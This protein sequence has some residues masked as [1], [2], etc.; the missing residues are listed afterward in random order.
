MANNIQTIVSNKSETWSNAIHIKRY[1]SG[2]LN[3]LVVG[4]TFDN[5][6][7]QISVVA[8]QYGMYNF[9]VTAVPP[10]RQFEAKHVTVYYDYAGQWTLLQ[11]ASRNLMLP[12]TK[13]V[14]PKALMSGFD[15]KYKADAIDPE[16]GEAIIAFGATASDSASLAALTPKTLSSVTL[17]ESAFDY[18]QPVWFVADKAAQ[19]VHLFNNPADATSL[20]RLKTIT[21]EFADAIAY[22]SPAN[23]RRMVAIFASNGT[24]T[25][26]NVRMEV[27][28]TVKLSY[29]V[30]RVVLLKATGAFDPLFAVF[31]DQGRIH[32]LDSNF[33]EL[34][35]K[36]DNYYVNCHETLDAYITRDGKLVGTDVWQTPSTANF[37]YSFAPGTDEAYCINFTDNTL[38]RF[39]VKTS[40]KFDAGVA[41][42]NLLRYPTTFTNP[43]ATVL[44]AAGSDTTGRKSF[45][46]RTAPITDVSSRDWSY[47]S[48]MSN[49]ATTQLYGYVARPTTTLTHTYLPTYGATIPAYDVPLGQTVTFTFTA[50]FDD[51]DDILPII[52][53]AGIT[54]EAK[55]KGASVINVRNG[56]VVTVTASHEFLTAQPFPFS[57]GRSNGLVEVVPD[58]YPDPFSYETI[59]DVP[60]YSWQQTVEKTMTGINE[61]IELTVT[62]D[63]TDQPDRVEL[64]VNG[65]LQTAPYFMVNGDKFYWRIK[66]GYNITLIDMFAGEYETSW[67]IYTVS[68]IQFDPVP[69]RAYAEVGTLY[70][71]V[72]LTNDG[73]T[74]LALTIDTDEGEFIQGGKEVTLEIGQST[75]LLFTP[76]EKDKKYQIKFGSSRYKYTWDVWTHETWLDPQPAPTYSQGMVVASS[77]QV[78][79]DSIPANFF[80]NIRVPA[81]ILFEVDGTDI[82][83]PVDSRGVYLNPFLMEDVSCDSVL[84]MESYPS[85]QQPKTLMLGNA[86]LEWLHDFEGELEYESAHRTEAIVLMS[87]EFDYAFESRQQ[88]TAMPSLFD[89]FRSTQADF[90]IGYGYDKMR[91]AD[92]F[93]TSFS[94][95]QRTSYTTFVWFDY[96]ASLRDRA[97]D[98]SQNYVGAFHSAAQE[99]AIVNEEWSQFVELLID[100]PALYDAKDSRALTKDGFSFEKSVGASG[101]FSNQIL[102]AKDKIVFDTPI[103]PRVSGW[104][105]V[106]RY[107]AN[108]AQ[109]STWNNSNPREAAEVPDQTSE[110]N[111]VSDRVETDPSVYQSAKTPQM[112][113]AEPEYFTPPQNLTDPAP[114]DSSSSPEPVHVDTTIQWM[115]YTIPDADF[116]ALEPSRTELYNWN[117]PERTP[118]D[119]LQYLNPQ[120]KY[121]MDWNY[122]DDSHAQHSMMPSEPVIYIKPIAELERPEPRQFELSA[123]YH[124]QSNAKFIFAPI[125][126]KYLNTARHIEQSI[127]HTIDMQVEQKVG[128][129]VYRHDTSVERAVTPDPYHLASSYAPQTMPQVYKGDF[130]GVNP[131]AQQIIKL[132]GYSPNRIETASYPVERMKVT[133]FVPTVDYG[134]P[135]PLKK[136]YFATELDAL[137]NAI[138]VWQKSPDEIFGVQQPD[139][140]WTWAIDIPCG[141]YCGDFGCDAR[142]YLAGG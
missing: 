48:L 62:L 1:P 121:H 101:E 120:A 20:I 2:T 93:E 98:Y 3:F 53:P 42:G 84:K 103:L 96:L 26:Y 60:D 59:Y 50:Q 126:Y 37:F 43:T 27:Q 82:E 137:Q 76:T 89:S 108:E 28:P 118:V 34:S 19:K 95:G 130:A 58:P 100:M 64:Y 33:A 111:K 13:T 6:S 114:P 142:G 8:D 106:N 74:A 18:K 132:G 69:N 17:N 79:F 49:G 55:V 54:W 97:A 31:D 21:T 115:Q 110:W 22:Y 109:L 32:K 30:V 35:L 4:G 24:V 127:P 107:Q 134:D 45:V 117:K 125:T 46:D 141:E 7:D 104:N 70:Q 9:N 105:S 71:T 99:L 87:H 88:Q 119:W 139:G 67:G 135:D 92:S 52:L 56:D 83:N 40:A 129:G 16:F 11:Q 102:E 133:M 136:G 61:R 57:V 73:I 140:T 68:E 131:V 12:I 78:N 36:D 5:S 124:I 123:Y 86:S 25:P 85:H 39:N 47:M 63:G 138:N 72:V 116:N 113:N 65:E 66:H 112:W 44:L 91:V 38:S 122:I 41:D 15:A 10:T 128:G 81:G 75:R 77:E 51:S 94:A 23:H 80:T 14:T 29:R 90:S